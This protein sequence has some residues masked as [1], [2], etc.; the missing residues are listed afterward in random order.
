MAVGGQKFT[1]RRAELDGA[2]KYNE[3]KA[4][5]RSITPEIQFA[6][7]L[8]PKIDGQAIADAN[9]LPREFKRKG[10][11]NIRYAEFEERRE[12]NEEEDPL[13][14]IIGLLWRDGVVRS[15][16]RAYE[17]LPE[18][19]KIIYWQESPYVKSELSLFC[20]S[21][22]AAERHA[23][24]AGFSKAEFEKIYRKYNLHLLGGFDAFDQKTVPVRNEKGILLE[25]VGDKVVTAAE[26]R[27]KIADCF[28]AIQNYY[29][30]AFE[31][32]LCINDKGEVKPC[33]SVASLRTLSLD[34]SKEPDSV[35]SQEDE[36]YMRPTL[37]RKP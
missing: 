14:P 10:D 34:E 5:D 22:L 30:Q 23:N 12:D 24:P 17:I 21:I 4:N 19:S 1:L 37:K 29:A 2:A 20:D 9:L 16:A 27:M 6:Q 13:G 28:I 11:G 26:L 3:V 18:N 25:L 7:A 33:F 36:P 32:G 8:F 15:R 35:S 31:S